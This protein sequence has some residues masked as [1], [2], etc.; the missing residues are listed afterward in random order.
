MTITELL[1][2]A[3]AAA[4]S[5][6]VD[7]FKKDGQELLVRSWVCVEIGADGPEELAVKAAQ[8]SA[9]YMGAYAH[10]IGATTLNPADVVPFFTDEVANA[11]GEAI[12]RVG[13]HPELK[14]PVEDLADLTVRAESAP[15]PG[16]MRIEARVGDRI[17]FDEVLDPVTAEGII[18]G[19][20]RGDERL[21]GC[22]PMLRPKGLVGDLWAAYWKKYLP[23]PPNAGVLRDVRQAFYAGA[24][25]GLGFLLEKTAEPPDA[26]SWWEE[27]REMT[28]AADAPDYQLKILERAFAS[29]GTNVVKLVDLSGDYE[30]SIRRLLAEVEGVMQRETGGETH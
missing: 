3:V 13:P 15:K 9:A 28:I 18:I 17:V 26:Q 19:I 30:E 6:A 27:Y 10:R 7:A 23:Q 21:V 24:Y 29:G 12:H 25:C 16:Y 11:V 14:I 8:Q 4:D 2:R 1:Q 22:V 5:S 20:M